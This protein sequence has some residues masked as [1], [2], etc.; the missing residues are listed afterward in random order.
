MDHFRPKLGHHKSCSRDI[1][2]NGHVHFLTRIM[3]RKLADLARARFGFRP[4]SAPYEATPVMTTG[5]PQIAPSSTPNLR[6]VGFSAS[7]KR[8]QNFIT[9][10]FSG[11]CA[12]GDLHNGL[13]GLSFSRPET[14]NHARVARPAPTFCPGLFLLVVHNSGVDRHQ[15]RALGSYCPTD[16]VS[17]LT[18]IAPFRLKQFTLGQGS[19]EK[20]RFLFPADDILEP[21]VFN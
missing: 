6:R 8:L 11:C 5:I 19:L 15:P 7:L 9:Y 4:Q 12:S 14:M 13:M 17:L 16:H 3:Q 2:D 10:P 1:S 21:V 20:I 18:V